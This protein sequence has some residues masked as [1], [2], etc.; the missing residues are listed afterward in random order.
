MSSCKI[1]NTTYETEISSK[2]PAI[3]ALSN[4]RRDYTKI[5]KC[6]T[7]DFFAHTTEQ[8]HFVVVEH[9]N[10]RCVPWSTV[11]QCRP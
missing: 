5:V 8:E 10:R 2:G 1:K 11:I 4:K 7:S 9:K 6:Y 3:K